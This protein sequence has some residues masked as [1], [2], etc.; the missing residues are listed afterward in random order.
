MIKVRVH[1][2]I[3][4][5][6]IFSFIP[7][8]LLALPTEESLIE[9]W[10]NFQKKDPKTITFE[11]LDKNL[12]HFKTERFPF[13][14]ELKIL[15]VTVDEQTS[16]FENGFVLGVVEVELVDLPKDFM[17][18][19]SYSYSAWVQDNIL[20]YDKEEGNWL[21]DEEYYGK[22]KEKLPTRYFMDILNY[23]PFLFLLLI[24]AIFVIAFNVQRKNKKYLDH[25]YDLSEKQIKFM[26]EAYKMERKNNKLLGEILKELK[27]GKKK[28]K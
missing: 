7:V 11:K 26:E 19:Y 10:E 14:G 5:I 2:F 12:Y 25:A 4:I 3:I 8:N 1:I 27:K 21:S 15:N 13:D 24:I 16:S 17:E 28:K 23:L 20:Y 18:K 22:M 9:A 6:F